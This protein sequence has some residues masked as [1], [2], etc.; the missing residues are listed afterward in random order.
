MTGTDLYV[1]KSQFVPV[2]FEPPCMSVLFGFGFRCG[3]SLCNVCVGVCLWS[4]S[5][6]WCLLPSSWHW[7]SLCHVSWH[8]HWLCHIHLIL[9]CFWR[10]DDLGFRA[11]H[12][13]SSPGFK[14]LPES[15]LFLRRTWT[16][17]GFCVSS[18]CICRFFFRAVYTSDRVVPVLTWPV[19]SNE[20]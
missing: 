1:N 20:T 4:S 11:H 8:W 14:I 19:L 13:P 17:R 6:C 15:L 5:G 3:T 2:I 10:P 12:P 7:L 18:S 9:V 16:L